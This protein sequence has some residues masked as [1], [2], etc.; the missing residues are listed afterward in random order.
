MVAVASSA[1]ILVPMNRM[2][3]QATYSPFG[4]GADFVEQM[5]F[6]LDRARSIA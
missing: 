5:I 6:R 3:E 1:K 4:D 2:R